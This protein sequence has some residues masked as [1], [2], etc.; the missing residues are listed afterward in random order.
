[1]VKDSTKILTEKLTLS[2]D[3]SSLKTEVEHLRSQAALHQNVLA[4]R[5]SLQ[6]QLSTL[7]VELETERRCVQRSLAKESKLQ[8]E[9]AIL[10]TQAE[11]LQLDLNRERKERQKSEQGLKVVLAE[12]ES[13]VSTAESR[14]DAFKSELK[15]TKDLLKETQVELER[16]RS[17]NMEPSGQECATMK[18]LLNRRKRFVTRMD[19]DSIIGTPGDIPAKKKGRIALSMLGEKS[20]FSTTP[21]LSR[22][23][24]ALES[25]SPA[26]RRHIRNEESPASNGHEAD[27]IGT[28]VTN[29]M[30][31]TGNREAKIGESTLRNA[32]HF[33]L[34]SKPVP[35]RETVAPSLEQIAE[36]VNDQRQAEIS[37][38]SRSKD[39]VLA[40]PAVGG[41]QIKKTKRK[42][43]GGRMSKS[44]F[45]DE[46]EDSCGNRGVLEGPK[47]FGMGTTLAPPNSICAMSGFGPISPLKRGQNLE[48]KQRT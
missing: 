29:V 47:H 22:T 17:L 11:K 23:S 40:A 41:A 1:M 43:L 15:T 42:L 6:R 4:E 39:A 3:L 35:A 25:P 30:D 28:P 14:S 16:M 18:T 9:D 19:D 8:Q 10:E 5:L 31:K 46:D 44:L 13:R 2:R 48:V 24:I 37:Q 32:D 26:S 36:E 12:W 38:K 27:G 7:Q 33:K 21:Y 45:N 20:T 34:N